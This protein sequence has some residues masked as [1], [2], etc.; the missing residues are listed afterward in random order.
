MSGAAAL[1]TMAGA[2]KLPRLA[3]S[4]PTIRPASVRIPVTSVSRSTFP[5]FSSMMETKAS[6]R[7]WPPPWM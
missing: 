7:A 5:R 6:L 2:R 4:T 1:L 3:V